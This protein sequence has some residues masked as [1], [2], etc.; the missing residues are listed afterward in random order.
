MCTRSSTAASIANGSS[1]PAVWAY[2]GEPVGAFWLLV[3]P[4]IEFRLSAYDLQHAESEFHRSVPEPRP[5]ISKVGCITSPVN[6]GSI[7]FHRAM[8]F[9][10]KESDTE[11]DDVPVHRDYDG[12]DRDRE[13]FEKMLYS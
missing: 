7:A 5:T 9:S 1:R 10:L 2:Q 3:G 6:E 8:S 13:V 4:G 12:S 11:I